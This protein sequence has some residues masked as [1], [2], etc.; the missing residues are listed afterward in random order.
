MCVA[1]CVCVCACVCVCVC[2]R[3]RVCECV[4]A[5]VFLCLRVCL[6]A[7]DNKYIVD[8]FILRVLQVVAMTDGSLKTLSAARATETEAR[9]QGRL[10][11][12]PFVRYGGFKTV[13]PTIKISSAAWKK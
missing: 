8:D 12:S 3:L 10:S 6:H 1:V 11:L 9:I 7:R 4:C 5:C 13:G 2:V